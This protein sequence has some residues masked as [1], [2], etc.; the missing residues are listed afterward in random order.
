M[1]VK[2]DIE[3]LQIFAESHNG[4]LLSTEHIN[5]DDLL[6]WQCKCGN[7]FKR[8]IDGVKSSFNCYECRNDTI[9]INKIKKFIENEQVICLSNNYIEIKSNL[10]WQCLICSYIWQ[11]SFLNVRYRVKHNLI[12][13]EKCELNK[14]TIDC[15]ILGNN[16]AKNK[17]GYCLSP[18]ITSYRE[19][20]LW[21]CGTCNYEW[22]QCLSVIKQGR[23]CPNCAGII[24]LTLDDMHKLAAERGGKC[25][26]TE[27]VNAQTKLLWECSNGHTWY[28]PS[29]HV[30][31]DES[32]CPECR[33]SRCEIVC[34][35][36]F[37]RIFGYKFN[38]VKPDW[39]PGPKRNL[40]LDGYCSELDLAFEHNGHQHYIL[41]DSFKMTEQRL[42]DQKQRDQI[43]LDT[44]A[45]LG[46]HLFVVEPIGY[47]S[48][49]NVFKIVKQQ[50][51]EFLLSQNT[52]LENFIKQR[53]SVNQ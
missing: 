49:P 8:T 10:I 47:R 11:D 50:V 40:E 35:R 42:I 3:K 16:L 6:E 13:C 14:K 37:E 33:E 19:K 22:W 15:T 20:I 17:N 28:A 1:A 45:N 34:R 5:Y 23:W 7:I 2:W 38:K 4:K 25:L 18:E 41:L 36:I 48:E 26:S 24:S 53:T 31:N 46:I 39:L 51:D 27:Y 9:T 43:K 44:C 32:W 30:R 12:V 29:R 52:S 21:K